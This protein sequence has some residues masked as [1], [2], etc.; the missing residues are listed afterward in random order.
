V[1]PLTAGAVLAAWEAGAG[2]H[3]LDRALTLLQAADPAATRDALASLSVAER[4]ARLLRLRAATLGPRLAT[5]TPCPRCGERL[6]AEL[7]TSALFSAPP[8]QGP[9]EARGGG[10][11]MRFRLPDSRDLA[12]AARCA[13]VDEARRALVERCVGEAFRDDGA[14]VA[15]AELSA[16]AAA[17]L[18]RAMGEAAPAADATLGLACPACGHAWEA[19]LDV[20][21][22][23]WAELAARARG[24]L[25]E[26]HALAAAY[27][28]SESEILAMTPA[29][30]RAYL[31]MVHG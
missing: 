10:V 17:A 4:D 16:E 11:T 27:H 2:Q 23:F 24:L 18:A 7:D 25:R 19:A 14:A 31:E 13:S 9:L 3:P 6:E 29:R 22:V 5:F 21:A 12:A 15:P 28:W 1:R 8:A 26:V 20:G 30:R